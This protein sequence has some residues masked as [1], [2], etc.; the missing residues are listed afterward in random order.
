MVATPAPWGWLGSCL[1]TS[2]GRSTSRAVRSTSR[3]AWRPSTSLRALRSTTRS[4]RSWCSTT[5]RRTVT[6]VV[7]LVPYRADGGRRDELWD[8]TLKWLME[9]HDYPVILGES[10]E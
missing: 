6:D 1:A 3:A 9:H 5:S 7:F 2:T 4:P 10:P 8:F